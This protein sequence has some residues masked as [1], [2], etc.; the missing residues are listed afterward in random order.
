[1]LSVSVQWSN[2]RGQELSAAATCPTSEGESLKVR[3]VEDSEGSYR[4]NRA[5]QVERD[6]GTEKVEK[7]DISSRDRTKGGA[8]GGDDQENRRSS[9]QGDRN[10]GQ[11]RK[12]FLLFR[13]R[14]T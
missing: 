8:K 11:G 4:S 13:D 6:R 14:V 12:C 5:E 3:G 10:S 7:L 1:V 2:I 9:L